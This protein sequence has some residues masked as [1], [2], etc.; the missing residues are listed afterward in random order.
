VTTVGVLGPGAVGGLVAGAL[1]RSGV[2]VTVVAR[3]DTA[4]LIIRDGL[5][6]ESERLGAFAAH[7]R[8]AV[9][10]SEPVDVLVVAVRAPDLV[11]ALH[12]V[13]AAPALVVP[14]L[15]GVEHVAALRERFG[16]R[17]V[18]VGAIRVEAERPSS[19]HVV[20]AGATLRLD[21]APASPAVESL[22]HLLR[23]AGLPTQVRGSGP[24][25][26]WGRFARVAPLGLTTAASGLA[27][28]AVRGHP[29]WR[30]ALEELVDEVAAVARAEGASVDADA[31]LRDLAEAPAPTTGPLARE[32]DDGRPG[33]LD[34][35]GGALVR[36]GAR[37]RMPTP[38]AQRLVAAVQ[39]RLAG[40]AGSG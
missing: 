30:M 34:A 12:R 24:D 32:V 10:L 2:A 29:T 4:S 25:L 11:A 16:G 39:A 38:T 13:R 15:D 9:A 14:L 40:A 22:A 17:A 28:G 35:L 18:V 37:H 26:L 7:P 19:G 6:V 33:E 8:A 31:A 23:A 1:A 36:A 21:L 27:L 3:E 20:Q 5:R